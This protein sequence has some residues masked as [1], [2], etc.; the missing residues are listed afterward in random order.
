MSKRST[1]VQRRHPLPAV[2][3]AALLATASLLGAPRPALAGGVVGTGTPQSCTNA[4]LDQRLA[5]GGTVTFNCGGAAQIIITA[6]TISA[7]TTIN[8]AGGITLSGNSANRL[9]RVNP[10]VRLTLQNIT[11]VGG[12]AG[13]GLHG[14]AIL[15]D[16]GILALSNVTTL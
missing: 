7:N 11:L 12:N 1:I 4:A 14:G 9:F 3:L 2:V 5:G 8:G 16:G 10:G 6:K 13:A 15:N